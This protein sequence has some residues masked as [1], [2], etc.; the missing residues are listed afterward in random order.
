MGI[1]KQPNVAVLNE[2]MVFIQPS[3]LQKLAGHQLEPPERDVFRAGFV[4]QRIA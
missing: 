4:R 2:L 1:L 3:H